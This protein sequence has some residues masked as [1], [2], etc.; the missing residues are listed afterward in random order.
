MAE[1]KNSD[2]GSAPNLNNCA[3]RT[4]PSCPFGARDTTWRLGLSS[5]TFR[6]FCTAI[7]FPFRSNLTFLPNKWSSPEDTSGVWC[8][9][10]SVPLYANTT[11]QSGRNGQEQD[12]KQSSVLSEIRHAAGTTGVIV[13][14]PLCVESLPSHKKQRNAQHTTQP[15][16]MRPTEDSTDRR[17]VNGF[18]QDTGTQEDDEMKPREQKPSFFT[19]NRGNL[20][21]VNVVVHHP[22]KI[23]W[24]IIFLCILLSVGL[25]L[26][27]FAEAEDGSPFTSPENEFDID[28]IRSIKYDSLRLARDEVEK[29][30]EAAG[31]IGQEVKKQ[32]EAHD[33]AYWIYEAQTPEGL[34]GSAESIGAMKEAFDIFLDDEDFKD[35]CL[36][37]YS[38][39]IGENETRQCDVP[40]SPLRMYYASEWDSDMVNS[41]VEELKNETKVKT[42]NDLALCY[43]Q[44]LYCDKVSNTTTQDE[45]SW[46]LDLASK[47]S[48][49]TDSWDMKGDLVEN[50]TQ[51]TELASY[52]LQVDIFKGLLDFG[53]DKQFSIDNPVSMYSRGIIYWGGPLEEPDRNLTADEKEELEEDEDELR[54]E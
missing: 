25:Q 19:D 24:G 11:N 9:R 45:I 17:T 33:L 27:V 48:N 5:P 54:K 42:F 16:M 31:Q 2:S 29:V 44:G 4:S 53:Y 38:T 50:Y 6:S 41:V 22:C 37:D 10:P 52:L 15:I 30:R 18:V 14:I 23:F 47:M 40:L 36:L 1:L 51:A 21:V 20:R 43:V 8:D 34:F 26:L 39:E 35:W 49:I 3:A 46:A 32:S 12:F 28:D 13:V 7:L